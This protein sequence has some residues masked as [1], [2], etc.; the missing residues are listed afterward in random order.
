MHIGTFFY[1]F[2]AKG[3]QGCD[4]FCGWS[5]VQLQVFEQP[6]SIGVKLAYK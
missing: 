6:N 4:L 3:L 5:L 2:V 1:S